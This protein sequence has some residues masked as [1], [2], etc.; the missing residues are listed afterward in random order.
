[1]MLYIDGVVVEAAKKHLRGICYDSMDELKGDNYEVSEPSF[2]I[3]IWN[4]FVIAI[5]FMSQD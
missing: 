1:M 4:Y 5:D 2:V 3:L